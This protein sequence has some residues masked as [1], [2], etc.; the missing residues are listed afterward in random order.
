MSDVVMFILSLQPYYGHLLMNMKVRYTELCPT[1]GVRFLPNNTVELSINP[2]FFNSLVFEKKV[3]LIWHELE[4]IV[5]GQPI[6]A[7]T[8]SNQN[9]ANVVMDEAINQHIPLKYLPTSAI[10]PYVWGHKEK[11]SWIEYYDIHTTQ[12]IDELKYQQQKK[13][14]GG[15]DIKRQQ[16]ENLDKIEK[17]L[18][19]IENVQKD[20]FDFLEM[21]PII[22]DELI[23]IIDENELTISLILQKIETILSGFDIMKDSINSDTLDR[24]VESAKKVQINQKKLLELCGG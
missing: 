16:E 9:R 11:L 19:N 2:E 4:H 10:L 17:T 3:G 21:E 18:E 6:V 22:D 14:R 23:G 20:I 15:I 7:A 1:A 13:Y 5:Y 8:V 24:I 12:K